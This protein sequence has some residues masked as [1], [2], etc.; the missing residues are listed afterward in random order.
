[1]KKPDKCG[2]CKDREK[3]KAYDDRYHAFCRKTKK[4]LWELD[5]CPKEDS[6]KSRL[7]L[8]NTEYDYGHNVKH[9]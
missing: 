6:R 5:K 3:A 1:M 7:E 9:D 4:W 8:E 2:H